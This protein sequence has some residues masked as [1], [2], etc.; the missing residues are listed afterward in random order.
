MN[1][2]AKHTFQIAYIKLSYFLSKTVLN[3]GLWISCNSVRIKKDFQIISV[4]SS[5]IIPLLYD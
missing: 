4:V 5:F 1:L 2:V 3:A